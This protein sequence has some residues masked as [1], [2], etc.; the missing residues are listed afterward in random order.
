MSRLAL[1]LLG[2][3]RVELDGEPVHIGRRK[4]LALLAYLAVERRQHGRDALATLLWPDYDQREARAALRRT[5]SVI[6][7]TLG[8]GLLTTD[9]ETAGLNPDAELW[10]DVDAFRQRLA[11]CEAH[12]HPT[13]HACP[14]CLA[15]LTEA[16]ELYRDDLLSGFTLP[17][18][19]AF[20]DWQR[21]QA[22][23]LRDEL[24]SALERLAD[25]HSAAGDSEPAIAAAR[26]RL[27]LDPL[28]EAAHRQL[29]RLYAQV[30]R[31]TA[32]LRQYREC[33]RVLEGELGVPPSAET[34]ALHERLQAQR[35]GREEPGAPTT[36][37]EAIAPSRLHNL[38]PQPTLFVGRQE[39]L[40]QI[41]RRLD[42]PA[43][44]LLTLV[45]PGGVGK[46]RL[47]LAA[48]ERQL[49]ADP[50]ITAE[51]TNPFPNGV[52]FVPLAP[53]SEPELLVP[54]IAS[55]LNLA[56]YSSG[57]AQEQL[58]AY[59]CQK[60]LLLV[61]DNFEH[62]LGL[63]PSVP[64]AGGEERGAAPPWGG[65]AEASRS[66]AEPTEGG[67]G[68]VAAILEAAPAVKILVTSREALNLQ[69]EWFHP[70][71]G[72]R[73]PV[74]DEVEERADVALESYDALALFAQSARRA[75]PRFDVVQERHHIARICQLVEGMPLAIEMA[76]AWLKGLSPR[77]IIQELEQGLD[78][79]S[80][81]LRGAPARH[82]S[83]RA[84]FDHSW[85]LLSAPERDVMRALSVFRGGFQADAAASVAGAALPILAGLV[86][87]SLLRCDRT[88]D[89]Y[90][91]HELLRQYGAEKLAQRPEHE[92]EVCDRHSAHYCT[93]LGQR[94]GDFGGARA[95][96]AVAELETESENLRVAWRWAAKRGKLERIDIA[97][98]GLAQFYMWVARYQ[99]GEAAF[100]LAVERAPAAEKW[101][102]ASAE[103]Q[104]VTAKLLVCQARFT[105]ELGRTQVASQLL[106]QSLNLLDSAVLANQD[107]RPER[108]DLL[109]AL[110]SLA[111]RSDYGQAEKLYRESM[112]LHRALGDQRGIITNVIRQA[113]IS[114]ESGRYPESRRLADE[115]LALYRALGD[116]NGIASAFAML[117]WIAVGQGRLEEAIRFMQESVALRRALGHR[118]L[119]A[120]S[121]RNLGAA[122]IS[123][124][125]FD[126]ALAVLEESVTF[127]GDLG[128]SGQLIFPDI[129]MG[130]AMAHLGQYRQ[131]RDRGQSGLALARKV[132]DQAGVAHALLLLGYVALAEEASA[133][134]QPLLAQSVATF[135]ACRKTD[136]AAQ[137]QAMAAYAARSLGNGQA[138]QRRLVEA[139]GAAVRMQA[140]HPATLALP[141]IALLFLDQREAERAVELYALASRYPYVANSRWF[142]DVAG[143]HIAAVAAT[144]RPEVVAA[145]QEQGKAR[146]L[147]ATAAELLVELED[148]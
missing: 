24:D 74:G 33:V 148:A 126:E 109:L 45:G 93:L 29:M 25:G 115:A 145:A 22:Q 106:Q 123:L 20:D 13:Q 147:W 104:R 64:P 11:A 28:R 48:A 50:Q 99:E 79:L 139:L 121:L 88:R 128:A 55:A 65:I 97:I 113:I 144:L 32:A 36:G 119:I 82:R 38:P 44:R 67:T 142:E 46:T 58:L 91:V 108:A 107:T 5:L 138:A 6:N 43:C 16:V 37:R 141:A 9:R 117:G 2:P 114:Y 68:L 70:V 41:A 35:A 105:R 14:A 10:L 100:R 17:D 87:K 71:A 86:E 34:T 140:F 15:L 129:L 18:S 54:T 133:T 112:N 60:Q 72:M 7:R 101:T 12:G 127:F 137:A 80:S 69:G 143:K 3:S 85:N 96:V 39:E 132:N 57:D 122:L 51:Q 47:A 23:A 76:A 52:F 42:D 110:G 95:Q 40:D 31:R 66:A 77:Q 59:L 27:E 118:G 26:H 56:F 125:R 135:Q 19:P 94:K 84:V 73:Y 116:Q 1:Y 131:A 102:P 8:E 146:D 136:D 4:A 124:G 111:E 98:D 75:R 134:A 103:G 53:L 130:V 83:M 63:P 92:A 78:I 30:G 62:L 90:A 120:G 81:S 49:P 21:F 61:L 89:R